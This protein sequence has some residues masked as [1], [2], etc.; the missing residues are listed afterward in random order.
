MGLYVYC[1]FS[2]A[3][4]GRYCISV[5]MCRLVYCILFSLLLLNHVFF[6]GSYSVEPCFPSSTLLGKAARPCLNV[7]QTS[8]RP[9]LQTP[10]Q[11]N[12]TLFDLQRAWESVA[13]FACQ[14]ISGFQII[15]DDSGGE[16]SPICR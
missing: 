4:L 11:H 5:C 7:Y 13:T 8:Q 15:P 9:S 10:H 14:K 1:S 3:L 6:S 16:I 2:C 12:H